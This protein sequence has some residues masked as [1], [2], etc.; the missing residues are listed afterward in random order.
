MLLGQQYRRIMKIE[1][2]NFMHAA[3]HNRKNAVFSN[4][5]MSSILVMIRGGLEN[6]GAQHLEG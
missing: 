6:L 3:N 4:G 5:Q 2:A 1:D